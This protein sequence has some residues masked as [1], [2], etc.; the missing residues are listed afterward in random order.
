MVGG[1]NVCHCFGFIC[2]FPVVFS[3]CFLLFV[4]IMESL[5]AMINVEAHAAHC[6]MASVITFLFCFRGFLLISGMLRVINV[7]A[8]A[9]T[10]SD[11]KY[12][13]SNAWQW[14]SIDQNLTQLVT[15][16]CASWYDPRT[17]RRSD[18]VFDDCAKFFRVL[19]EERLQVSRYCFAVARRQ[20]ASAWEHG[21]DG[22]R[23]CR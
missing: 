15:C 1:T 4:F 12:H 6:R 9:V 17:F 7:E 22:T 5:W 8:H 11:G 16:A 23:S 20:D 14:T 18:A 10:S 21:N 13:N 19:L 2:F 3:R